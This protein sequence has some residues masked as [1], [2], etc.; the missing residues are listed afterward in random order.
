MVML[1][2]IDV[3]NTTL[4]LLEG[5]LLALLCHPIAGIL[6]VIPGV[7]RSYKLQLR[8]HIPSKVNTFK[9]D[10]SLLSLGFSKG[11]PQ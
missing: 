4:K 1:Q 3:K 5:S 9:N 2:Q 7:F 11:H 8:I 6:G 10:S